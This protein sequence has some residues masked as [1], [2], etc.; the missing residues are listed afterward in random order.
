M[1]VPD[2]CEHRNSV[3]PEEFYDS[4]P[5]YCS[6]EGCGFPMEMSETLTQ[7]HCSNPRC[8][9]KVIQRLVAIANSL[10]V[11]DMGE[12]RAK[13]FVIK[14]EVTNPLD[15]FAY[16]VE[17][18]GEF[19]EGI[20]IDVTRKIIDQFK[21]KKK[22]TLTEYVKI[23]NIPYI[24]TSA[25]SIFDGYDDI[26]TAY[27]DIENGGVEFIREKLQIK[28]GS[29]FEDS[30]SV[31]ALKVLDSL[32]TY[33][34]DLIEDI[35]FVDIIKTNIDG[36]INLK[37]VC[38]DEV[39]APFKTKADFYATVNNMFPNIH[40]EFLNAV[41]K[42]IDYLVWAGADGSPA[43]LTNKVKKTRG[44]NEKYEQ[45]KASGKLKDGEHEIKILTANQF[46][47]LLK[48]L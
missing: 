8:P 20:S 15:I 30:I 42:K 19:G 29:E 23:A 46:I 34:T 40:V 48:G 24:Q 6:E 26:N 10:G 41:T 47:D 36:M 18:H 9:S 4:I 3:L 12:A 21:D 32:M 13:K 31:R 2:F 11:K 37:A 16:D 44:Y 39:G 38:S 35:G 17:K 1:L 14:H 5:Q 25:V 43:R 27:S 7:L 45:N 33:K 28:K 22:F